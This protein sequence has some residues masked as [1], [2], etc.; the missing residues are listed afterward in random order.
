MGWENNGGGGWGGSGGGGGDAPPPKSAV[1]QQVTTLLEDAA[2]LDYGPERIAK[3]EEAVRLT[4][5]AKEEQLAYGAR[6]A[7]V[8][9][10]TFGGFPEKALVA[11]GWCAAKSKADPETFQESRSSL[12]SAIDLLWAY[13][14]VTLQ[15]PWYPQ[16]TRAQMNDT[17]DDMQARYERHNLSL[18]PVFMQRTRLTQEMGDDAELS[19]EWYRKWQWARRDRYADCQACEV[20]FQMQFHVDREEHER[21]IEIARPLLEGTMSCAE[22]PH[23]T[24]GSLIRSVHALGDTDKAQSMFTRGYELVKTNRDFVGSVAEFVQYLLSIDDLEQAQSLLQRHFVWAV[25]N[26]IP[27]RV[28]VFERAARDLFGRLTGEVAIRL[29]ETLPIFRADGRYEPKSLEAF[30]AERVAATAAKF[31]ARNGNTH[32]STSMG[33]SSPSS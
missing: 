18:R 5:E 4:D 25:G 19:M 13:K 14:W 21:A 11:F 29:P 32:V 16:L 30:F 9:A 12:F 22:V 31:D 17:L 10:A 2:V 7:L 27:Y 6:L 23:V 33:A 26:R 3:T 24:L 15:V 20:N 8:E 28:M 1:E